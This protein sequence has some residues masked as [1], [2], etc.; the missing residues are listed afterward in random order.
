[1]HFNL[2]L[3]CYTRSLFSK[4]SLL[5]IFSFLTLN[6]PV[7]NVGGNDRTQIKLIE[8]SAE[9]IYFDIYVVNTQNSTVNEIVRTTPISVI[10]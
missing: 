9:K 6:I 3:I 2:Y 10:F 5:I 7:F 1:M 4:I 8:F